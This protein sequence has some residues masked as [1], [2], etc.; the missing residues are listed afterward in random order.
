MVAIT[1]QEGGGGWSRPP[2]GTAC[3]CTWG[4]TIGCHVCGQVAWVARF[5]RVGCRRGAPGFDFWGVLEVSDLGWWVVQLSGAG[6]I[7]WVGLLQCV[8]GCA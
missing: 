2:G 6:R 8:T 5:P 7:F 1:S 3:V 4:E